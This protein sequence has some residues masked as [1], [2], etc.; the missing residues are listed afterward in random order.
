MLRKLLNLPFTSDDLLRFFNAIINKVRLRL[1]D[2][3]A[4]NNNIVL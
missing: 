3:P 4:P 2:K 1:K